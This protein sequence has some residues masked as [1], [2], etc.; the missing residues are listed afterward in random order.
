MV[1]SPKTPYIWDDRLDFRELADTLTESYKMSKEEIKERGLAG[2]EWVTSDESMASAKNM[3]K[4]ISNN[5][6]KLFETWKPRPNFHFSK[7][8]E[9]PIKTLTH[10][11]VY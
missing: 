8:D 7:I 6:D 3:C 9:L 1:G 11:L 5:F 4:N 2:R 10:K